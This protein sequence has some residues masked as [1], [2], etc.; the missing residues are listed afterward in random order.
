MTVNGEIT[1]LDQQIIAWHFESEV[2]RRLAAL[3]GLCVVTAKAITK[4]GDRYCAA[5]SSSLPRQ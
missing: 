3:P 1:V 5:C 2:S 4:Q